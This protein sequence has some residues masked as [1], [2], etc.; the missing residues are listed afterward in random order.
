MPQTA[1]A[2]K[3][4]LWE[5]VDQMVALGLNHFLQKK[6]KIN[7]NNFKKLLLRGCIW[8]SRGPRAEA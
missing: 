4:P 2:A 5:N 8:K 7:D 1:C 6:M 3:L